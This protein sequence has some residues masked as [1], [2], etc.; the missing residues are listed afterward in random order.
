[1]LWVGFNVAVAGLL[2]LDLKVLHRADKVVRPKQAGI[3]TAVW[4]AL[5]LA[6]CGGLAIFWGSRAAG[7]FITG[8]LVEYAL[9]VDNLFVFLM[10][11][12]YFRVAPEY[13]HRLLFWGVLGAFVMRATL[14]GFG[15]ALVSAF[16]WLLYV[17]GAFLL[18]TG[19]RM[20]V[21]KEGEAA[22]P[23]KSLPLRIA[24]R[25]LP[26]AKGAGEAGRFF[27]REDGRL[28]VTQLFLVL[29]VLELTDLLFALDSIPAVM[30]ITQNAFIVYSSNVC[31]ILGLRSLFFVVASLMDRFHYLKFG[32]SLVLG[33]V[34]LKL[35][36]EHWIQLPIYASLAVVVGI[37]L[38]SIVISILRP[39]PA[40]APD[41]PEGH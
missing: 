10:V 18:F 30:G 5:S 15:T 20:F 22:S 13:Q 23:E 17:F 36:A 27:V 24:K 11:F 16:H 19:V 41:A 33:F 12:S 32:L 1:L 31:A 26:M 25:V 34:G 21:S 2:L 4:V 6:F 8:Y 38:V 29:F 7:E 9:S 39:R 14:I 28:R 37:L 35:L 3:W 40:A